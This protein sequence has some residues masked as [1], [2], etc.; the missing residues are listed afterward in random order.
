VQQRQADLAQ[1]QATRKNAEADFKRKAAL[2]KRKAVSA[3]SLDESRANLESARA[4]VLKAQAS[5]RQAKL[6]LSYTEV[7]S[8]I[9]GQISSAR[10]SVGNLVGPTSEPLATVARID[11]IHVTISVSEK[12]LLRSARD[13]ELDRDN[14][15]VTPS[16]VLSDGSNYGHA[17]A[18]DYLAPTVDRNTGTVTARAVFPNP[19]RLLVPGQ[20]V[21]MIVRDNVAVAKLAV[22]QSAVQQDA[23]GHFVL[24]LAAGDKIEK[25]RVT[26]GP[27]V[28]ND[29]VV[30]KGLSE[31][32]LIVVQGIQK[33]RPDMRVKPIPQSGA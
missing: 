18:F 5:L 13:G 2:V 29:W 28:D 30:E 11:P 6:D 23:S 25:R 8:P 20:F 24:V 1:A 19:G 14:P 22:P 12:L 16:L 10:Y 21:T 32:E 9:P 26:L 7:R 27:Q 17:G 4:S 3:A 31:G 33:V 15:P